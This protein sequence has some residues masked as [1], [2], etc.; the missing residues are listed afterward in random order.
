MPLKSK[1]S[2]LSFINFKKMLLCIIHGS[3]I[4]KINDHTDQEMIRIIPIILFCT[5][6]N[7]F[8]KRWLKL[9]VAFD[10]RLHWPISSE[11]NKIQ[12]CF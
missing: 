5:D 8:L 2:E 10:W 6:L 7:I 11:S 9:I 12:I 3:K 4:S 1:R